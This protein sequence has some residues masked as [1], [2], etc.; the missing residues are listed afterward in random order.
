[1]ESDTFVVCENDSLPKPTKDGKWIIGYDEGW[2]PIIIDD[3]ESLDPLTRASISLQQ[4]NCD[5]KIFA[6]KAN[7][8][9]NDIPIPLPFYDLNNDNQQLPPVK[10][11]EDHCFIGPEDNK[12][13]CAGVSGLTNLGNTCFINAGLQ[14]MF[15][16][17]K[18]VDYFLNNDVSKNGAGDE[19]SITTTFAS[20]MKQ[21]WNKDR[22]EKTIKS[23]EFKE[24]LAKI[25]PQFKDYRQHDCQEFLALLLSAIHDELKKETKTLNTNVA[26]ID[27]ENK[28]NKLN[29]NSFK[30]PKLRR[31]DVDNL[32]VDNLRTEDVNDENGLKGLKR[33][34]DTNVKKEGEKRQKLVN[35]ERIVETEEEDEEDEGI[36]EWNEY[37]GFNK[38]SIIVD[39][40]Q[41]QFRS[42]I[43]CST[44]DYISVTYEPFMYLPLPIPD[45]LQKQLVVT[46]INCSNFE[47]CSRQ[48]TPMKYS[49][50]CHKYDKV[51]KVIEDLKKLVKQNGVDKDLGQLCLAQVQDNYVVKILD[52]QT[53]VRNVDQSESICAFTLS[54]VSTT[55]ISPSCAVSSEISSQE[56]FYG[57]VRYLACT[58]C[59][60]E[61]STLD[62][63]IHTNE[64]DCKLC[65]HCL[66]MLVSHYCKDK[67]TFNCPICSVLLSKENF[68]EFDSKESNDTSMFASTSTNCTSVIIPLLFRVCDE[69][70]STWVRFKLISHPL[71]IQLVNVINGSELY[72]IV[73][74][75]VPYPCP[76][77]LHFVDR[78]GQ[79]CSR[80]YYSSSCGGCE[81]SR[82]GQVKLH[83]ED[84]IALQFDS[85][86][87]LNSFSNEINAVNEN[88]TSSSSPQFDPPSRCLTLNDCLNAF[89]QS[90]ML[91]ED[92]PWFC[93]MCTSNQ[94]ARKSLSIWRCPDTLM[95]YLKRFVFHE[96]QSI[97]VDDP[98]SFPIGSLDLTPFVK[99]PKDD[100]VYSL[101]SLICHSGGKCIHTSGHYTAF[102]KHCTTKEWNYFNDEFV[103]KQD[104]N[105]KDERAYIL[106][107]RK[108]VEIAVENELAATTE[109]VGECERESNREKQTALKHSNLTSTDADFAK[110]TIADNLHATLAASSKSSQA[111]IRK[112][113]AAI[114]ALASSTRVPCNRTTIAV[115]IPSA[116]TSHLIIPPKIFTR[117]DCTLG[118]DVINRKASVTC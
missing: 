33:L 44:C 64:C 97:K 116:I 76:Y 42:T 10:W 68:Y 3:I 7:S 71:L 52:N 102:S 21:V 115:I 67:P 46:L 111:S 66:K 94:R 57:P 118:S 107:Y 27:D 34:K 15:N 103:T 90:E 56:V 6:D 84:S 48:Q 95:V 98:V 83:S 20:L 89:S 101:Q 105:P 75:L 22:K 110:P 14:C 69:D 62:L 88:T 40:F 79:Q 82:Y 109:K 2:E 49:I 61:K 70:A 77:S 17:P 51:L 38:K 53:F 25:F 24:S 54:P 50:S 5:L 29:F 73:D 45:A 112:P 85:S 100:H 1:M 43:K 39:S 28:N 8:S 117:I 41:G 4:E 78:K 60:E 63:L 104:P 26:K 106:F 13:L 74:R 65:S 93:P 37:I 23:I 30:F 32:V 36:D 18:L 87:D 59:L 35:M 92:N 47:Y 58:I 108:P 12:V 113:D 9:S 72:E 91:D 80:C 55:L 96:M 86:F 99:G 11:D 114:R 16:N 81:I 19:N 31:K